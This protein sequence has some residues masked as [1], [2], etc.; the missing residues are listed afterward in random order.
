MRL[1]G[2]CVDHRERRSGDPAGIRRELSSSAW[3][4]SAATMGTITAQAQRKSDAPQGSSA[5]CLERGAMGHAKH[6]A[7]EEQRTIILGDA[8]ACSLLPLAVR[9]SAPRGRTP[10]LRVTWTQE[11]LSVSGAIPSEGRLL[12]PR[13]DHAD[14]APDVGRVVQMLTRQIPGHLLVIWDG[15]SMHHGHVRKDVL[16]KGEPHACMWNACLPLRQ[17]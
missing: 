15:A 2:R 7:T 12:F 10:I 4:S 9:T 6:K 11:H 16:S 3:S 5:S 14:T 13:Q 1:P 8:A 17:R